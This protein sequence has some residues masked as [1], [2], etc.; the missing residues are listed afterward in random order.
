MKKIKSLISLML[1][2]SLI[3]SMLSSCAINNPKTKTGNSSNKP[4]INVTV[5]DGAETPT[6]ENM[7]MVDEAKDENASIV[8]MVYSAVSYDLQS[9]G[10]DAQSC[11][12][13][14]SD[15]SYEAFGLGYYN[16][17]FQLFDNNNYASVGFL[18]VVNADEKVVPI[19]EDSEYVA[20]EPIDGVFNN[21]NALYHIMTYSCEDI[22]SGH[23]IFENKYVIYYQQDSTTVRFET[24]ENKRE[25]YNLSLGSLYDFDNEIFI[26]DADLFDGYETHSAI[27]LFSKEDY[28]QLEKELHLLSEQQEAN[29]YIVEELNIVYISPESIEAYLASEEEDTFFGY[30]VSELESSLGKGTALVYTENGFEEAKYFE[31]DPSNYNWKSFL[32]KMGI[33][34][35]IILIGTVLAPVTGGA[36]FSCA[37]I[38]ISKV[39]VTSAMVQTLGTL[40]VG[41]T[42]D[43]MEGRSFLD[44]L[45]GAAFDGLDA[46][47][48]G[49]EIGAVIGSVGVCSGLIKPTACFAAGTMIA[50]PTELGIDYIPIEQINV[51]DVVFSYNLDTGLCEKNIVTKTFFYQTD[52]LI[53]LSI[54]GEIITTTENHPFYCADLND[55]VSAENLNIGN[56]VLL[57]DGTMATIAGLEIVSCDEPIDVF[58]FTVANN[59]NYFVSSLG[60]LVHNRCQE[61]ARKA[62]NAVKDAWKNEVEAVKNGTSKY[63]WTRNELKQL[64][65]NGKVAGYDGCHIVDVSV[66]PALAGDSNNIIFLKRFESFPGEVCHYMVHNYNW[67]NPSNWAPVV[68][69]MPQFTDKILA[70]GGTIL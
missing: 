65:S 9:K 55:W 57:M 32:T 12:A 40:T 5:I 13:A 6:N 42:S 27:E 15:A 36:S 68:K 47:S 4:D 7:S 19:P 56:H 43:M 31:S 48:N 25:N 46:F 66:N 49:F 14:T 16:P 3:L 67:K 41:V 22:A 59:H 44:S 21:S 54:E 62:N 61:V 1:V 17:D 26:Y 23:F 58:N 38:T 60:I 37:L 20:V 63:N 8:S 33:G 2:F 51:G 52:T 30:N 35:G 50:I 24:Y 18:T 11:V 64:L 69:V 29:G 10:F 53:K 39:A 28:V 70:V 45:K 34:C